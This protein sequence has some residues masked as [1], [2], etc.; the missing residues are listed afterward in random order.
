RAAALGF[1]GTLRV[2]RGPVLASSRSCPWAFRAALTFGPRSGTGR[3]RSVHRRA[4]R[5]GTERAPVGSMHRCGARTERAPVR[6]RRPS[7]P[8]S[9]TGATAPPTLRLLGVEVLDRSR[10]CLGFDVLGLGHQ[11]GMQHIADEHVVDDHTDHATDER[12]HDGHPPI[13]TEPGS[14]ARE[15]ELPE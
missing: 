10:P 15:G 1:H 2:L 13:G 7:G 3:A 8:W 12:A 11:P 9:R 5:T 6:S 14:V 4:A